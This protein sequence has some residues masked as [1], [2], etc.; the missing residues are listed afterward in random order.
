MPHFFFKSVGALSQ[1]DGRVFDGFDHQ[2]FDSEEEHEHEARK[3]HNRL[4]DAS[5]KKR[6]KAREG[7]ETIKN[8]R[9]CRAQPDHER[10][11]EA[12][13]CP[14]VHDGQID[15]ANWNGKKQSTD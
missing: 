11:K 4:N 8:L 10:P 5:L 7:D 12:A 3:L 1:I 13:P 14:F 15:R 9:R 2:K 6:S